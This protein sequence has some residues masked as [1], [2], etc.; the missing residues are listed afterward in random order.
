M[1][2]RVLARVRN[3]EISVDRLHVKRRKASRNLTV[4]QWRT[5]IDAGKMHGIELRVIDLNAAPE[6]IFVTYR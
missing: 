5:A 2:G 3:I 6:R 4:E 1:F